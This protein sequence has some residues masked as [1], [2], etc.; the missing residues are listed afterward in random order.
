MSEDIKIIKE[1]ISQDDLLSF[2]NKPFPEMI[3]FVVDVERR[4]IAF[5][6]EMHADAE[7]VLIED[8]SRQINLWGGNIYPKLEGEE[9]FE[10]ISLINIRPS[11]NNRSMEIQD[12]EVKEK[13]MAI[14]TE[15]IEKK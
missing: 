13:M 6:G 14:I 9:R 8:G 11:Q 15:L 3:K 4:L 10:F 2:L 12:Q 7:Q 1:K 5:G